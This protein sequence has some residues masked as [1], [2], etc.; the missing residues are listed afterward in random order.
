MPLP[1]AKHQLLYRR[2]GRLA[3]SQNECTN[4]FSSL[5]YLLT[6]FHAF[7]CVAYGFISNL[8]DFLIDTLK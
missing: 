2:V 8:V 5:L 4:L 3:A 1:I 7:V 6:S